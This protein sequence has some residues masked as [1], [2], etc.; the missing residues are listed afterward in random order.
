MTIDLP[1][2]VY[3]Q[4]TTACNGY[5]S[6]CPQPKAFKKFDLQTMPIE[7]FEK[8]I[9]DLRACGYAGII[10]LF[11]QS[12]PLLDDR[13]FDMIEYAKS[14]TRASVEIST[15]GLL[16]QDQFEK[17]AMSSVDR[18]YFN[19]GAVKYGKAPESVI[20]DVNELAQF[21]RVI[22][23]Y[24]LM[25]NDDISDLFPGLRV[26]TFWASNRGGNVRSVKHDKKTRFTDCLA[27]ERT[28]NIAA[29]GD[30]I[31]C[32]NDYTRINRFGNAGDGNV[33]DLWREIPRHFDYPIC[34][35]C[36]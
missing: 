8:I 31:L 9:Y 14:E 2:A 10:G 25:E 20:Q 21:K 19:Y 24:P 36:L 28:L 15:N 1:K 3:I 34:S 12:E 26:D 32:C 35:R 29:N 4:P 23:N 22:V 7:L 13:I 11:L 5:C 27:Q 30:I 6:I 33:I 17:L 18:I 16:I